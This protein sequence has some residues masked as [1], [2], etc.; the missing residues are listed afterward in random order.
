MTRF[1]P[2]WLALRERFDSEARN[3]DVVDAVATAFEDLPSVIVTDLASGTG[4]TRRALFPHLPSPQHWR[5]YD[6]DLSLLARAEAP[7][8]PAGSTI[9]TMPVDLAH[10]LEAAL[11]SAPDLIATS[12]LLDLVSDEWLERLVTECAARNLPLYAALTYNGEVVFD[13]PDRL[14][15][16]ILAAV[17]RHQTRD[18]GFGPALGAQA[19]GALTTRCLSVG[20]AI[21]EGASDWKIG[22][23]DR[24]MQSA[25]LTQWARI[26]QDAGGID[27]QEIGGWFSRRREYVA[28]GVSRIRVGHRD[29]FARPTRTR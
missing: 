6:N 7:L 24:E 9:R 14:D 2:D 16:T 3:R 27:T 22:P 29:V 11:D 4:S 12:A 1:A 21:T 8:P 5:M 19:A 28:K 10:D 17:N 15:N 18:K 20:F 23:E 25:L 13:P 26:A